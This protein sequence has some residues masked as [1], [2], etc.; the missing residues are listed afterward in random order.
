MHAFLVSDNHDTQVE[1]RL[2]GI[3]GVVVHGPEETAEAIGDVL[4]NK[5]DVGILVM[6]EK[7]AAEVPALVKSL[8]ERDD[9]PLLVEIPDRHGSRRKSD[10]LMRYIR[11]AIGVRIE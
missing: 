11:D 3:Q 6:T 8:R 5:T 10:F 2:A 1:M 9:P 7:A 4:S